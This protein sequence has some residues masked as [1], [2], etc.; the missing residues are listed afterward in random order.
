MSGALD[1]ELRRELA[2]A[3]RAAR[4]AAEAGARAALG[5]LMVGEAEADSSQSEADRELRRRLRAHGRQLG[6]CRRGKGQEVERLAREVAYEHWHRMLFARFLTE[7]GFLIDPESEAAITLDECREL[8]REKRQDPWTLA[9]GFAAAM[10]PQIFR[11]DDPSLAVELPPETRQALEKTL[12][13]LPPAVFAADDAFGWSYQYWQADRKDEVNRSGVKIGADEL[14]AV[15]QLFTEP[16]MVRF[17]FHNT[18]GAWRAGRILADRPELANSAGSEAELRQVV[19]LEAKDGYDFDYLRFVRDPSEAENGTSGHWRPASGSFEKWPVRAAE[20]R[21]LDPCCGSGHFLVEALHLLVRLRM[22]EENLPLED[23][24]RAV[25]SDN[26]HGM[27]IDPRCAQIAAFSVAFAAWRLARS[28]IKL[29]PL[30]I[31]CSGLAPNATQKEWLT[32][33]EKATGAAGSVPDKGLDRRQDT[34]ISDDLR[35][36]LKTLHGLFSRAPT[37]GSLVDP[38]WVGKSLFAAKFDKVRPL[39]YTVLKAE[40]TDPEHR[41]RTVAAAGMAEAASLLVGTYSLV[42]TNVPYLGRGRQ[43]ASLRESGKAWFPASK[44]DLATMFVERGFGWTGE[45]GTEAFVVPQN[46]LYQT[47]YRRLREDLLRQRQ[48]R[49]VTRLGPGAFETISGHVVNVAL[50]V[51]SAQE[52]DD[53]WQMAGLDI[54]LPRGKTSTIAREKANLLPSAA[55]NLVCQADQ[56]GNPDSAVLHRPFG[57]G[58]WLSG[59]TD[60]HQGI[61]TADYTCFGRKFWE[62]PGLGSSWEFQ[63][64]TVKKT[65]EFGGREHVLHWEEGEGSINTAKA[66]IYRGGGVWNK[67]GI[68]VSQI[69]SLPVTRYTGELF[70]NNVS[71]L[72]PLCDSEL[73]AVWCFCSSP[74]YAKSVREID[75]KLNVTN[76]TLVKIPFDLERWKAVAAKEYPNGLPEPYSDDPTQSIFHGHPCGSVVWDSATKRTADGPR[77]TDATVLQVAVA[78]L[79]GYRWPAERDPEMRL[80]SEQRAWVDRCANLHEFADKDGIVCLPA[81]GGEAPAADRLRT[82]LE[83]AFG[84]WSMET[85]HRLL[86]A[87]A[88]GGQ[89]ATSLDEWLRRSFFGE[90]CRLF[91]H[92]P[93]IWHIWDGRPDGFHAFVNYHR[94]AGPDGEGR[95]TLESLVFN[96]LGDWINRQRAAQDEGAPG[97]DTRL[98]NARELRTRLEQI[99]KGEPPLDL[100]IRWKPLHRQ[101]VGWEPDL[102]DGVRLNIRPF[103]RAE[104]RKGGR[105]GAGLLRSKPN[106]HWKM[107]GGV[108]PREL[109][110]KHKE[111]PP[112]RVRPK[113]D[114]PWFWSCPGNGTT[115]ERTDFLGGP[116]FDGNRW[117]D[118]HY[119]LS[120]KRAAQE[121]HEQ[122][123]RTLP[124][125]GKAGTTPAPQHRG[126]KA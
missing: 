92:R 93:F 10:L 13:E 15:T 2:K 85:Q 17:L 63:Q 88:A 112:R 5:A 98:A 45:A 122:V 123:S 108:E 90:H 80:A 18:V 32:L 31:A 118:L 114:F 49:F 40:E 73:A 115:D 126:R 79:L 61:A 110:A 36:T 106:I 65:T 4:K 26:L 89:P 100:F 7:N 56:W 86:R 51:V 55:V 28:F 103:L 68:A 95:R 34:N 48:W 11:P 111:D 29:P 1:R 105:K 113:T 104:I 109:R 44:G 6:D 35:N 43:E 39:L 23:A 41:E 66:Y 75:Q 60:A 69:G 76:A 72:G 50:I 25:L 38:H 59:T 94:L 74:E 19:R 96:Y 54:S 70:D 9:G 78:R 62:F 117:N 37:L 84:E 21:I 12:G 102:D 124:S 3:V 97:A 22:E 16:Y 64:T 99:L 77:R 14:P 53:G 46:W 81:V 87:A 27:E 83:A 101:P 91:H 82:I 33:A 52:P 107:D 24:I 121:R 71:A 20:L 120:A 42:I 125:D 8:A 57:E 58:A 116:T 47:T 30:R 67:Q 119:T